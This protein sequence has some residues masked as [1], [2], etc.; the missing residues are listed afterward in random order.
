MQR[1]QLIGG[2]STPTAGPGYFLLWQCT[3]N[4]PSLAL[5]FLQ[6]GGQTLPSRVYLVLVTEALLI[7]QISPT[8]LA[9]PSTI[10]TTQGLHGGT[11]NHVLT[12]NL[13]QLQC[14]G[15]VDTRAFRAKGS[16][17]STTGVDVYQWEKLF[18]D[19]EAQ[20]KRIFVEAPTAHFYGFYVKVSGGQYA[21]MGSQELERP[22]YVISK[23]LGVVENLIQAVVPSGAYRL[24]K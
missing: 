24:L 6:Q 19:T 8:L 1:L 14:V 22:I 7:V 2:Q 15:S 13:S 17:Q 21:L 4:S 18:F 20:V 11:S 10:R 12:K 3:H 5:T 9:Q 16:T 23:A